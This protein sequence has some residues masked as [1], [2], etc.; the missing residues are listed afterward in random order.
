[1]TRAH[2]APEGVQE[3][4]LDNLHHLAGA[5]GAGDG[6]V[7]Y[8]GR[9]NSH[10]SSGCTGCVGDPLISRTQDRLDFEH[11]DSWEGRSQAFPVASRAIA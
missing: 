9:A 10:I 7:L 4:A 8:D 6:H 5:V 1:M 3:Y 2:V 11:H